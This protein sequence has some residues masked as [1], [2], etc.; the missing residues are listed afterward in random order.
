MTK[1]IQTPNAE[2]LGPFIHQRCLP[3]FSPLQALFRLVPVEWGSCSPGRCTPPV[4]R[5]RFH[6]DFPGIHSQYAPCMVYLPTFGW[7]WGHVLVNIPYIWIL[8]CCYV[9]TSVYLRLANWRTLDLPFGYLWQ[10]LLVE[11]L[12]S[13]GYKGGKNTCCI[14]RHLPTNARWLRTFTNLHNF[15]TVVTHSHSLLNPITLRIHEVLC[16][17]SRPAGIGLWPGML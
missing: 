14:F 7:F 11:D 16:S 10:S 4:L 5:T 15:A 6:M 17:R 1:R 2:A 9:L 8:D 12:E 13:G 3:G